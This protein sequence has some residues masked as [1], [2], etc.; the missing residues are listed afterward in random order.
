VFTNLNP[1]FFDNSVFDVYASLFAGAALVPFTAETLS[2][3][4]EAVARVGEMGCTIYF[5]VPSLLAYFQALKLIDGQVFPRLRLLAFGGEGYPKPMLARLHESIGS[6]VELLNVYG[7]TECTCICSVYRICADDFQDLRGY[8]PLG[9]LIPNFSHV[10]IDDRGTAVTD[11]EIGELCLGGPCVGL[12]YYADPAQSRRVFVQNPTHDRFFDRV[13]RTG[14]LVRR[15]PADGHLYF[16]GRADTQIKRQGYRIELGEI[17][18][19]LTALPGVDEAA[20][21]YVTAGGTSRIVAVAASRGGVDAAALR[22]ELAVALPRYMLPERVV[23]VGTLM[24][25]ANGKIDRSG[26]ESAIARGEL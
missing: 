2:R 8:P 25:N 20:V 14:D 22:A 23:V 13:Y 18:H 7:P 16:V 15:D 12:G 19:A 10:I 3:P 6:R 17:E 26:I 1:L 21:V 24:K 11:G 5:S 9:A 4:Q